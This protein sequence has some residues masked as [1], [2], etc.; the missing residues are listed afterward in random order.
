MI[1]RTHQLPVRRQCQLLKLALLLLALPERYYSHLPPS[2]LQ[3]LSALRRL[4]SLPPA[5]RAQAEHLRTQAAALDDL[6]LC[7]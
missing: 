1:D 3:R 2:E 6:R 7:C 4:D 5:V